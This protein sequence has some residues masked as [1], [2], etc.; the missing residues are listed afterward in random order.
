M[1]LTVK[2]ALNSNQTLLTTTTASGH[3]PHHN[4]NAPFPLRVARGDVGWAKVLHTYASALV[5]G[6]QS[7]GVG[8]GHLQN[9]LSS[10]DVVLLS[11]AE[12]LNVTST[13]TNDTSTSGTGA[14]TLFIEGLDT[15]WAEISETVSMNGTSLVVT[16][17]SYLRV[18]RITVLTTGSSNAN[19]GVITIQTASSPSEVLKK[20]S[21]DTEGQGENK[22]FSTHWSIPSGWTGFV[23]NF[24]GSARDL[25][26][27]RYILVYRDSNA[28]WYP[29]DDIE[30]Y[31]GRTI[32]HSYSNYEI[33]V[34]GA[35]DLVIRGLHL[36]DYSA[37]NAQAGYTLVYTNDT[38]AL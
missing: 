36:D 38:E 30:V 17:K 23:T 3:V 28:Q 7:P 29:L 26:L 24:H 6:V 11:A 21:L 10:A 25:V 5:G 1:T 22:S 2:D 34:P 27:L 18:N 19:E 9:G 16:S 15:S 33:V 31:S 20:I 13:S 8:G 14:R 12:Q 37:I 32:F 35:S 4:L